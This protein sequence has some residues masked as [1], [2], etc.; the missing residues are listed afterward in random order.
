MIMYLAAAAA[1]AA[2]IAIKSLGSVATAVLTT[3]RLKTVITPVS[4]LLSLSNATAEVATTAATLPSSLS[5]A[6][7]RTE[8]G[9][10]Y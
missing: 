1:A 6:A 5:I 7:A 2:P 10:V 8:T 9:I 3:T 4:S